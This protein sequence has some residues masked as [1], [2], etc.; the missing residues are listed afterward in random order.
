[1]TAEFFFFVALSFILTHELDAIKQR[2]WRIIP[3]TSF[4]NDRLGYLVFT[5]LHVPL[6][7]ILFWLLF[8]GDS[9]N[10]SLMRGLNIFFVIHLFLHLLL[11]KHP[12][13]EFTNALSWLLITGAG[14]SGGVSLLI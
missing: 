1:M 2:E 13:N 11:I 14:I 12:K 4:L 9:L 7:L 6:F 5:V 8:S 3:L 10:L